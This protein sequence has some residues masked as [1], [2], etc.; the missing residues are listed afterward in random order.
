M[1]FDYIIE[2]LKSWG[3]PFAV[4]A[5]LVGIFLLMQ[6]TGEII[7]WA[8]KVSPKILKLRK[9]FKEKKAEKLQ[10]QEQLKKLEKIDA[11]VDLMDEVKATLTTLNQHYDTDNITQRNDWMTSVNNDLAWTHSQAEIYDRAVLD[12]SD[13]KASVDTLSIF[14]CRQIKEDYRNRILDFSHRLKNARNKPEPEICSEEEFR[15]IYDTYEQYEEFLAYT[16][17]ENHQVD[18]AME[19]IRRAERGELPNIIIE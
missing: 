13:L 17:D 5:T 10:H 16:H 12:L 14:T 15:K 18:D 8:G 2:T 9:I 7:E 3:A 19:S 1:G 11:V 6:L 4:I